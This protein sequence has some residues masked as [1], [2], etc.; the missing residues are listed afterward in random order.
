MPGLYKIY[1]T[2]KTGVYEI[3][4][5]DPDAIR[6]SGRYAVGQVS[7][8]EYTSAAQYVEVENFVYNASNDLH[9]E[10]LLDSNG[11]PTTTVKD[12]TDS[13]KLY[14]LS[15]DTRRWEASLEEQT[16]WTEYMSEG[17]DRV[18]DSTGLVREYDVLDRNDSDT[19]VNA[20]YNDVLIR[21]DKGNIVY[22]VSF[23]NL[24]S[25][26]EDTMDANR[27][28]YNTGNTNA[29]QEVWDNVKPSKAGVAGAPTLKFYGNDVNLVN[30]EF[31]L[32]GV[33]AVTYQEAKNFTGLYSLDVTNGEIVIPKNM[34][35]PKPEVD[36]VTYYE[37]TILGDD[38]EYYK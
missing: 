5:M 7:T 18:N 11:D 20:N 31:T 9:D 21:Y 22:A 29:A 35:Q 25:S 10:K 3:E 8:S 24:I 27:V 15:Y 38:G 26:R 33:N 14:T 37:G 12:I 32:T 17:V 6:A 2:D 28:N 30:G 4:Y 16:D 19:H 13:S 1:E 23:A 36:G 34:A